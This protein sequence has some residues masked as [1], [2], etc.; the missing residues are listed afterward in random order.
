MVTVLFSK[1]AFTTELKDHISIDGIT[2]KFSEAV[3]VGHFVNGDYYVVGNVTVVSISPLAT[4]EN[5]RNGSVLN[6]PVNKNDVSPFD[7]RAEGNRYEPGLRIYP[8]FTMQPGDALISSISINEKGDTRAW[9]REQDTPVSYVRS[10]SVLTCLAEAVS[11]DAFRPSYAD[12]SQRIYH[13]DSLRRDLLPNLPKVEHVPD[14]A[15]FASHFRRPWLDICFFS[16]DAAG[17]YQAAYGREKGRAAGMA[18]LLLMLDFTPAE[19][20]ALL[21]NF[22]Q[23]GIDLWGIIRAGYSG[24]P[25]HGGHGTGR[26]WP[27]IFAGIMLDD[28]YMRSPDTTYPNLR[29][30]EDMQTIYDN[31]WS[32]AQVVYAG[33]QGVWNELQ[34]SSIPSW[35]PYEHLYPSLWKSELGGSNFHIG[36]DYRRCCTSLAWVGQGLAAQ[37]MGAEDY[38]NHD[39][40]FSYIDRWMTEDDTQ[41]LQ[42]LKNTMGVDYSASWQR[43]GQTWDAFVNEMWAAYAKKDTTVSSVSENVIKNNRTEFDFHIS[44][45]PSYLTINMHYSLNEDGFVSLKVFDIYGREVTML[46]NA[47]QSAGLQAVQWSSAGLPAGI[48]LARLMVRQGSKYKPG[49]PVTF[50]R[51]IFLTK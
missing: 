24:W 1:K 29:F 27:V 21:V 38:W 14:I 46:V 7:D 49:I 19:K 18:S 30:G 43:Q 26:K 44:S 35:G 48:Y 37:L 13:A 42:I 5:G 4:P 36:E 25:A 15:T 31:G 33:H 28:H 23:Y 11:A 51:K 22:V 9:L 34:V 6:L 41:L 39:A 45:D 16:F 20:E 8:P 3:P 50:S 40:F 10:V 12:R 2:W 32:G 17:E 47:R